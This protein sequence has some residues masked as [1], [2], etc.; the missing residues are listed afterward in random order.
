L[1]ITLAPFCILGAEAIWGLLKHLWQKLRRIHISV[2]TGAG[3]TGALKYIT[4]FVLI[5]YFVFTS[6][7]V[8]ELTAQQVTDRVDD[9]YS[10]ALSSH[11]IDFTGIFDKTDG[12][13]AEWLSGLINKSPATVYCDINSYKIVKLFLL[14]GSTV[15]IGDISGEP[16][17]VDSSYLYLTSWNVAKG[18]IV[19]ATMLRPG[20]RRY[21]AISDIPG[22]ESV[23][24]RGDRIYSSG[25]PTIF[26]NR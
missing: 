25:G 11:R 2:D 16:A 9:P 12:A 20:L 14:P 22:A 3:S 4:A 6:G 8:Y 21:R 15:T 5:P 17:L 18:Q 19:Q 7:I 13:A 23:I 1:L 26:I 24:E 10:I